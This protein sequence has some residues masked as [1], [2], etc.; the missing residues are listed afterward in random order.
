MVQEMPKIGFPVVCYMAITVV[1]L[2]YYYAPNFKEVEGHI[3]LGLFMGLCMCYACIRSRTVR[4]RILKFD[5][6]NNHEI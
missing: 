5:L 1:W 3:S 6:W 4:D 2:A